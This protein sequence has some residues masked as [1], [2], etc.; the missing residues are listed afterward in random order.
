M[1]TGRRLCTSIVCAA[2]AVLIATA[3]TVEPDDV[4]GAGEA[5]DPGTELESPPDDADP[6]AGPQAGGTLRVG[7]VIDPV[8]IDP[9]FIVDDEGELIVDALFD[10]LVRV[11]T[12]GRVE[13][14]AAES[15]E[16]DDAGSRFTFHLREAE[17]H[18]GT[19]VI[20]DD[21]VRTFDRIV[22][23]TADPPSFLAYLLAEVVGADAAQQRGEPLEGVTAV[24]EHTLEIEL[25]E[26][27][28][29]FLVT[30]A[31]P[32]LVPT[33]PQAESDP[34]EFARE[35]V[36][37]G[38]FAMAGPREPGSFV[39][40]TAAEGHHEQPL[41]DEVLFTIYPDD[42]TGEQQWEDLQDGQLHV[43]RVPVERRDEV[44]EAFG[45][46]PDGY[47][48]PGLV[49]GATS[50]AYMYGFN[51]TE[52]PFDDPRLRRA[53]SMAIDRDAL[54]T[55]LLD[56]T[57]LPA[58][59]IVPPPFPGSQPEACDHCRHDPRSAG[60]LLDEVVAD[61]AA[62]ESE[63]ADEAVED[64]DG[65]ANDD[66]AESDDGPGE[67]DLPDPAQLIGPIELTHNRGATHTAVAEQI[68]DD[69]EQAL[70]LE[71]EFQAR[72][73]QPFVRAVR[74]GQV[75]VFRLGWDATVP[76]AGGYL[77]PLFH[78]SQVGLD[79][80]TRY[81]APD[82][83]A[84]LEQARSAQSSLVRIGAYQQAERVILD[85]APALPVLWDRHRLAIAPVVRELSVSPFG[86][87]TLRDAWLDHD[88]R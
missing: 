18:D 85:D 7:L 68:A 48:G 46:S 50:S 24:D 45:R 3:C 64:D 22:D 32:S 6:E 55:E 69:I 17:F 75:P 70:G 54:A 40:L 19:P 26:P 83:D 42:G 87:M 84:L 79:N 28:P 76:D 67:A 60:E 57:R 72:D 2:T 16:V 51:V 29:G 25:E 39:R 53:L 15:Y 56:G 88:G 62:R 58:T 38:A 41:L 11:D 82:V 49:D 86:R 1:S 78:S 35:P 31:D 52:P 65:A 59:S 27:H 8:T 9:R 23:G 43:G 66:G 33:P 71:V 80:L 21:F 37:N 5:A 74:D 77:W 14:A 30:L 10:P 36:G 44:A 20:A 12:D 47:Q 73:L 61:L 4:D 81:D 34:E 63:Q 13:P